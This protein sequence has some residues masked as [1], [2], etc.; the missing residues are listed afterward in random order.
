MFHDISPSTECTD[1]KS[2]ADDLA[3]TP[4]VGPD[5]EPLRGATAAQPEPGDHLVIDQQR[6][7]SITFAAQPFEKPGRRR[8]EAHVGGHGLDDHRSHAIIERRHHVVG[9]HDRVGD[10]T[11]GDTITARQALIGHTTATRRQQ[12]VGVAVIAAGELDERIAPGRTARE[13]DRA[14]GR[15][16]PR[17]HQ[18][19]HLE[20]IHRGAERLG[21]LD[22]AG[23]GSAVGRTVQ[24]RGAD[25]FDDLGMRVAR[26]STRRSSAHSRCISHRRHPTRRGLP[27]GRRST[28]RRPPSRTLGRAS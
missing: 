21:Q 2:A 6:A 16:G 23:G 25:C 13:P 15:F 3:E 1:R 28:A 14:H 4:Q 7:D 11:R 18:S 8:D 17:R 20:T 5:A 27:R 26:R 24:R 12:V 10:R 9:R 22:F 19:H